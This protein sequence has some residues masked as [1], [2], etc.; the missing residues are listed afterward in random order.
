MKIQVILDQKAIKHTIF[1]EILHTNH[2][3]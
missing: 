3:T 2:Q 1:M